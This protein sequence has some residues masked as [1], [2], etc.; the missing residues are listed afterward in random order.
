MMNLSVVIPVYNEE[1]GV[2]RGID[3]VKKSLE[4]LSAEWE[5]IAVNDGSRDG[6]AEVLKR[7]PNIKVVSHN[8][9]RGYGASLKTGILAAKYENIAITD[10]DNTYPVD[11]LP[12][13]FADMSD[14]DMV[15]G[16]R[17]GE[18]VHYSLLKRVA[19]WPIH[20]LA[21]YLVDYKI[22]DLNSG[23]FL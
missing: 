16:A 3:A 10:A 11:K 19:K 7:I 8:A 18:Q 22:P 2:L 5:I 20:L 13:F 23:F 21:N 17:T 12:E 15:V 14:Y 4:K 6:T 9:N 1:K